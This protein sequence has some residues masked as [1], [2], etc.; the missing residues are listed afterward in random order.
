M[1]PCG[2]V[3][4]KCGCGSSCWTGYDPAVRERAQAAAALIMHAATGRQFGPCPVVVQPAGRCAPVPLYQTFTVPGGGLATPYVSGGNW[5]NGPYMGD[6]DSGNCCTASGCET[7]LDGPTTKAL[8]TAVTVAGEVVDPADY[9]VMD[10]HILVRVDGTCWP[11]CTNWTRQSPAGFTVAYSVGLAIPAGVQTAFERLACEMAKACTGGPCALPQR[12]TR[13]TRQG[14]DIE[15][16]QVDADG[17]TSGALLTG[18]KDVDD[19]IKALNPAR[20][21][22]APQV[23]SLDMP[24]GRRLT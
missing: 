6:S 12:M 3:V 2:W 21:T 17:E 20:L 19:V 23:M 1:A 4:E 15:I 8:I 10:G 5:Y 11:C 7:Y 18:I 22:H 9:V 13:L 14:V 16:E 24:R